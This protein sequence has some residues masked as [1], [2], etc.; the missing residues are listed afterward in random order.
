MRNFKYKNVFLNSSHRTEVV[1]LKIDE[2]EKMK[3]VFQSLPITEN[4]Y[5]AEKTILSCF[6]YRFSKLH[7]DFFDSQVND[8]ILVAGGVK[9]LASPEK[10]E[11]AMFILRQIDASLRLHRSEKI[12]VIAHNG[13]GAYGGVI[14]R[15]FYMDELKR[16]AEILERRFCLLVEKIFMDLDGGIYQV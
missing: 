1:P 16:A 2:G 9:Q 14:D 8:Y 10:E 3:K 4:S 15:E 7:R 13:C 12:T 6:D 11:D 5:R